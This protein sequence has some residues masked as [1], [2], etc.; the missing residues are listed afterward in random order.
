MPGGNTATDGELLLT[1]LIVLLPVSELVISLLNLLVTAQV[2]PRPLPKLAMLDGVPESDRTMIVVPVIVDAAPRLAALFD[3]L[4]VRFLGNRDA[5]LH[6]ALLSD[7][8]D[9][10]E[11]AMDGEESLLDAARRRVDELNERHGPD[12]FYFF[13]RERRWNPGEGRWM[14]WERKRGKL[15]EFNRLLRGATDTSFTVQHGDLS[16]LRADPL[17]HHPRLGYAAAD[18]CRQA[19]WSGRCRI[20]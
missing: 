18:G 19:V 13:H 11:A 17:R 14:G 16:V 6:F 2:P 15:T 9:A 1:A 8:A 20:R 10:D 12:R 4:E 5:C 3:D 7:F